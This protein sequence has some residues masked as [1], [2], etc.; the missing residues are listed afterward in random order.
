M[1]GLWLVVTN[2]GFAAI[3][4]TESASSKLKRLTVWQSA[5]K[6]E[7]KQSRGSLEKGFP[8]DGD[9]GHIWRWAVNHDGCPPFCFLRDRYGGY[10]EAVVLERAGETAAAG[11]TYN[12]SARFTI[13]P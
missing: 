13:R 5:T 12:T 7:R 11:Q 2:T 1:M 4:Q 8:S 3:E 10:L 6:A 9:S